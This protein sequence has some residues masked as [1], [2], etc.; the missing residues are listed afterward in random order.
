MASEQVKKVLEA[1]KGAAG[2][3]GSNPKGGFDSLGPKKT[4]LL[5]WPAKG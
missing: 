5:L 2:R 3:A 4:P 1:E